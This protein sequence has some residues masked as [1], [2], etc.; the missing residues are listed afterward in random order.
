MIPASRADLKHPASIVHVQLLGHLRHQRGLADRLKF[1]DRK[2][3]V[4]V[5]RRA[6][7]PGDEFLTGNLCHRLQNPVIGDSRLREPAAQ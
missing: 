6:K 1:T 4:G 5:R 2:G 3:K 7:L